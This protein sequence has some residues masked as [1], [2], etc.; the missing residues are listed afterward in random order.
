MTPEHL[1]TY[2]HLINRPDND[3]QLY[4]WIVGRE[5]PPPEFQ[6]DVLTLLQEHAS[7]PEGE[8]RGQQP[9]LSFPNVK[10]LCIYFSPSV[11]LC[12]LS[13]VLLINGGSNKHLW[14]GV[15]SHP[16]RRGVS[17]ETETSCSLFCCLLCDLCHNCVY[18]VYV[19]H[20]IIPSG[21]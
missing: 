12:S 13:I 19:I 8:H 3:W 6:S 5:A 20:V 15:V 17:C 16:G 2:D 1:A 7:N 10:W 11:T 21:C 9:E 14:G 18:M 4:A